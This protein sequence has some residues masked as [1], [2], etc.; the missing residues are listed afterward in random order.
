[1]SALTRSRACWLIVVVFAIAR[2]WLESATVYYLRVLVGRLDP[3]QP[4]PLLIHGALGSVELEPGDSATYRADVPHA[5]INIAMHTGA[6][7]GPHHGSGS[8]K[9]RSQSK[10]DLGQPQI[11]YRNT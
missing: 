3:Y 9:S 11:T 1:M 5:I 8:R 6:S 7:T 2:A 4:N 10:S